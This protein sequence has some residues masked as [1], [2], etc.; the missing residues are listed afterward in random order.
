MCRIVSNCRD[1][2]PTQKIRRV[3]RVEEPL[4]R[5]LSVVS[6]GETIPLRRERASSGIQ[7]QRGARCARLE[8]R[9]QAL[10]RR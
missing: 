10:S 9:T 5:V 7:T 2:R 3:Q 6:S 4:L 1:F 8:S